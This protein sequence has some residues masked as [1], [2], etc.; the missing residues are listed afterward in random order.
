M[1]GLAVFAGLGVSVQAATVVSV[2]IRKDFL[3][4]EPAREYG[5]LGPCMWQPDP[6]TT[7]SE[8]LRRVPQVWFPT[9]PFS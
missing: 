6:A 9:W 7:E 8:H 5:F 4:P 2:L 1:G 3:L